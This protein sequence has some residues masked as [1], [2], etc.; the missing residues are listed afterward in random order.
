MWLFVRSRSLTRIWGLCLGV[1]VFL[2]SGCG[3]GAGGGQ[4]KFYVDGGGFVVAL[5]DVVGPD[6][7]VVARKGDRGGAVENASSLSQDGSAWLGPDAKIIGEAWV[8]GNAQVY[9]RAVVS[10]GAAVIEDAQVYGDA[11]VRDRSRVSGDARVYGRAQVFGFTEIIDNAQ[12]FGDAQVYG[13]ALVSGDA[14]VYGRAQVFDGATVSGNARVFEDA[15]VFDWSYSEHYV[16]AD[17][18]YRLEHV[19]SA[20]NPAR[21][22]WTDSFPPNFEDVWAS[23]PQSVSLGLGAE[24]ASGPDEPV[25]LRRDFSGT[26][27]YPNRGIW[28]SMPETLLDLQGSPIETDQDHLQNAFE[29]RYPSTR[30]DGISQVHGRARVW[31][32]STIVGG[33]VSQDGWVSGGTNVEGRV[34]GYFDK[35]GDWT[36]GGGAWLNGLYRFGEMTHCS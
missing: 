14:Q 26:V 4:H 28:E 8:S 16:E 31:G 29:G 30:V 35:R 21:I 15:R 2:V 12:V 22:A 25:V 7:T 5:R 19:F 33:T 27:V 24:S 13:R 3:G 17:D 10:G 6:G 11:Q 18:G 23:T 32:G 36:S 9:G 20:D 34:C 1:A